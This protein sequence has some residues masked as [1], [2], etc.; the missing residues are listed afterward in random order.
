MN[1][2]QAKTIGVAGVAGALVTLA[3]AGLSHY[4]I[5]VGQDVSDALLTLAIAGLGW[6]AHRE[7]R[8]SPVPAVQETVNAP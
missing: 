3:I 1:G 2:T 4:G 8:P 6:F 7:G 5:T